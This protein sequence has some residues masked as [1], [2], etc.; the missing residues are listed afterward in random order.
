MY[1]GST[2]PA[3]LHQPGAGRI[4]APPKDSVTL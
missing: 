4:K 1:K 2:R 3:A